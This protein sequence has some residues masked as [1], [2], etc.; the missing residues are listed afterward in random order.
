M[1]LGKFIKTFY[2]F[3]ILDVLEI[4]CWIMHQILD[5]GGPIDAQSGAYYLNLIAL[6]L[7]LI[8]SGIGLLVYI[9]SDVKAYTNIALMKIESGC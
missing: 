6:I 9:L 4:F 7:M 1:K 3:I 5:K 8:A 2:V